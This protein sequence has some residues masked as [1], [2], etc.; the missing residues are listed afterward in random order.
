LHPE[1]P[2]YEG[3][4]TTGFSVQ[5]IVSSPPIIVIIIITASLSIAT[6]SFIITADF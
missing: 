2:E 1:T 5:N 6:I 4:L 3:I